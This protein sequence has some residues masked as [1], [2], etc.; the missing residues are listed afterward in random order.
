MGLFD[1]AEKNLTQEIIYEELKCLYAIVNF[2]N[3]IDQSD[4]KEEINIYIDA[5]QE[6]DN[7]LNSDN[8]R[9][10]ESIREGEGDFKKIQKKCIDLG[11]V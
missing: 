2:I 7:I 8:N 3:L 1:D 6:L 5:I 9:I 4:N 11:L 10:R